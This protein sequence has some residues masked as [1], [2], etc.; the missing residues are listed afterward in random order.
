L[1]DSEVAPCNFKRQFDQLA[2]QP[3]DKGAVVH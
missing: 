2:R 3:P 1:R